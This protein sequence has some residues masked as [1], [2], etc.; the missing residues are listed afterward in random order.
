MATRPK[1]RQAVGDRKAMISHLTDAE[2]ISTLRG[3]AEQ[4]VPK[5]ADPKH[6]IAWIAADRLEEL[7]AK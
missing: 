7:T 4:D 1:D 6:H 2:I 3:H 5:T